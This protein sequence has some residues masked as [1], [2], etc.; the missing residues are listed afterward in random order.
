MADSLTTMTYGYDVAE[1]IAGILGKKEAL[2]EAFH[3]VAP[4]PIRWQ[5]VAVIYQNVLGRI[6]GK[7]PDIKYLS[8]SQEFSR[9]FNNKYQ[10]YCDRLYTRIFDSS[11]IGHVGGKSNF[12]DI[13]AGLAMCLQNFIKKGNPF[14]SIDWVIQ[15]WFDK[16][17]GEKTSLVEID[18][19][20]DRIKYILGRHF[21]YADPKCFMRRIVKLFRSNN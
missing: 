9:V 13:E 16:K 5:D 20:K 19:A 4:K 3:I 1:G 15:G 7:R 17:T 2:G 21:G 8:D 6:T 12:V 18:S 11:K 14:H 10:V